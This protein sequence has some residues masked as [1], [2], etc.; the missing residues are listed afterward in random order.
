MSADNDSGRK[1]SSEVL[2]RY[3]RKGGSARRTKSGGLWRR[4]SESVSAKTETAEHRNVT[5][6]DSVAANAEPEP[7]PSGEL[8][9]VLSGEP[10]RQIRPSPD[11]SVHGELPLQLERTESMQMGVDRRD[12]TDRDPATSPSDAV[13]LELVLPNGHSIVLVG[14]APAQRPDGLLRVQVD[15]PPTNPAALV[16]AL[17]RMITT[18]TAEDASPALMPGATERSPLPARSGDLQQERADAAGPLSEAQASAARRDFQIM[19]ETEKLRPDA[20]VLMPP[21]RPAPLTWG[22]SRD[23]GSTAGTVRAA[24]EEAL[25]EKR[26]TPRVRRGGAAARRSDP[27]TTGESLGSDPVQADALDRSPSGSRR[28]TPLRGHRTAQNAR[29]SERTPS[30]PDDSSDNTEE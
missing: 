22:R 25:Q 27:F 16:V 24:R 15:P 12:P 29:A 20:E 19:P 7:S 14:R 28:T 5:S 1:P 23:L 10:T 18:Q 17:Q 6:G 3:G 11:G 30:A 8:P 21:P 13:V 4:I 9:P 26:S 2:A